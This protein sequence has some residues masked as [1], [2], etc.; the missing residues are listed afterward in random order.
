MKKI[1]RLVIV[2]LVVLLSFAL[3][4]NGRMYG[5]KAWANSLGKEWV[6][7]V[8]DEVYLHI[9]GDWVNSKD[10]KV[11]GKSVFKPNY[12][13]YNGAR[14]YLGDSSFVDVIKFLGLIGV[15][16]NSKTQGS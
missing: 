11:F 13:D 4:Q 16:D 5:L 8:D 6:K 15:I 14:I 2:I 12:L 10:I 1:K 9:K 3:I 7:I